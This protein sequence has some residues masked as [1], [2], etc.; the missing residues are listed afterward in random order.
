MQQ[1]LTELYRVITLLMDE[2]FKTEDQNLKVLLAHLEYRAR[3]HEQT[4]EKR[5]Y[6]GPLR[7][8]LEHYLYETLRRSDE[9]ITDKECS[10]I[11]KQL[12]LLRVYGSLGPLPWQSLAEATQYS[13]GP[14]GSSAQTIAHAAASIMDPHISELV[15]R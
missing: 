4:L 5:Q 1:H 13:G 12:P 10:K 2:T 11:L 9:R 8:S 15:Y 3:Q 6:V 7:R 14:T